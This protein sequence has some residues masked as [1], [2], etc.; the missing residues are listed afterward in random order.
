MI[1]RSLAEAREWFGAGPADW[2][3]PLYQFANRLAHV[4]FLRE[5]AGVPTWFVNV[6]FV[7]D[8]R[9]PT[10]EEE[11]RIELARAQRALG[12]SDA[13][14]PFV[15][16]VFLPGLGRELFDRAGRVKRGGT[17]SDVRSVPSG[18]RKSNRQKPAHRPSILAGVDEF[19]DE[20]PGPPG[21]GDGRA[22]TTGTRLPISAL[23]QLP[24]SSGRALV[25]GVY[26]RIEANW[27]GTPCRSREN[28]RLVAQPA[29]SQRNESPEKRFEK[30]LVRE[31]PEWVNMIPVASGV[32]PDVEEGGRRIDL[33]RECAPGWFEFIELKVGPDCDTPLHAAMEILGYGMIYLFS[34]V[35]LEGLGYDPG[36]PLL[37]AHRI[38]L[39]VLAPPAAYRRGSLQKLETALNDGAP[40]AR[41]PPPGPRPPDGLLL[42]AVPGG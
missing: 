11:W 37:S 18:D 25:S 38:S 4:Y 35:H 9:T 16:N 34:R 40:P 22:R 3:G 42:R 26:D 5:R 41:F 36:N 39:K 31:N 14:I 15:A 27:P 28:W 33:A 2:C 20:M 23:R 32:L 7:N 6:C 10:S 1:E 8:P 12:F 30:A 24:E 29:I 17:E 19:V 21:R 13:E